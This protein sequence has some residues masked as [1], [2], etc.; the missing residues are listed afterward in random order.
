MMISFQKIWRTAITAIAVL[1][2]CTGCSSIDALVKSPW[3]PIDLETDATVQ[4]LSFIDRDH[5]WLVGTQSTIMETQDGG[6]TW[7]LKSLQIDD[8]DYRFNS[9]SFNGDEGWIV[10][11]PALMLHTEDGGQHWSKI[12]LSAKLP[13]NPAKIVATGAQTA[14]MV[15]DVGAIYSTKD[16]GQNWSALVQEAFGALRNV[17]RSNDGKYVAVSSRGSFYSV[18][19]P[20][21]VSWEPHNRNSSRRVQGMGFAPDGQ[22]WMLNR[23]GSIQFSKNVSEE[24]W[25]DPFN[26]DVA[27]G[28]GLLDLAYRNQ[29]EI[30]VTGGSGRLLQ[31]TDGGENWKLDPSVADIPSNLYRVL[32]FDQDLGFITGQDG[33][34]L[35]YSAA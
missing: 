30:W 2:F 26:P 4:D 32:F 20:G 33:T 23:G 5:G 24:E 16:T 18:W 35:K 34:L 22:L 1:T 15:T 31:S 25:T 14:E 10:G 17:N 19:Y 13:G 12:T 6:Q 8:Q 3:V 28:I 9:V 11:E 29:D 7:D 27:S 21:E